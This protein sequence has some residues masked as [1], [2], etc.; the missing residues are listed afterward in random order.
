M[1]IPDLEAFLTDAGVLPRSRLFFYRVGEIERFSLHALSGEAGPQALLLGLTIGAATLFGLGIFTRV[2]GFVTWALV[3]SMQFRNPLVL[4]GGDIVLRT[5]LFWSIF[6][7]MA[8]RFRL[9]RRSSEPPPATIHSA[10]GTAL[11]LQVLLI[12]L[13]AAAHKWVE[14]IW[15]SLGAFRL[16]MQTDG[17]AT[18][19]GQWLG[20]LPLLPEVGTA[21]VLAIETLGPLAVILAWPREGI[22]WGLALAFMTFHLVGLAAVFRFGL[23]PFVMAAAWLPFLPSSAWDRLE[24]AV[25][26]PLRATADRSMRAHPVTNLVVGALFASIVWANLATLGVTPGDERG[27]HGFLRSP[28]H[29]LGLSQRWSLWSTPPENRYFVLAARTRDG[30]AI[31]LRRAGAPLDFARPALRSQDARWWKM[32]LG[33]SRASGTPL[34][35]GYACHRMHRWNAAQPPGRQIDNVTFWVLWGSRDEVHAG[36]ARRQR[37]WQSVLDGAGSP[38]IPAM[39]RCPPVN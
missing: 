12:Y 15:R 11:L 8:L 29:L 32:E 6:L 37:L 4:N 3:A 19:V 1:R 38:A 33:L 24:R 16:A 34:R 30:D 5:L 26:T 14:P 2:T 27:P 36:K 31:D 28:H 25:R 7:P 18:G 39:F 20:S 22:R 10:A 23:F 21:L 13:F 35:S 17:A 9:G